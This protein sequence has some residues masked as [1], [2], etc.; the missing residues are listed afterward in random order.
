MLVIAGAF[1]GMKADAD[2]H[3]IVIHRHRYSWRALI[4]RSS[5]VVTCTRAYVCMVLFEKW[6]IVVQKWL[7]RG[8]E[9]AVLRKKWSNIL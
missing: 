1:V 6:E 5:V 8:T 7:Q 2:G 3:G 9:E 4:Q